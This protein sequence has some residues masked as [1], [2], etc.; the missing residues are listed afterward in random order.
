MSDFR[1]TNLNL[2][3]TMPKTYFISDFESSSLLSLVV[4]IDNYVCD[5]Q[6]EKEFSSP[7]FTPTSPVKTILTRDS[8]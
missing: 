7:T 3:L 1:E 6:G 8:P 5:L 4:R 2:A